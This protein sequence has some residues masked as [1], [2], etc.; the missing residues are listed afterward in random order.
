MEYATSRLKCKV[1][2]RDN[3]GDDDGDREEDGDSVFQSSCPL[4]SS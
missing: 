3:E 4:L 1:K 2:S